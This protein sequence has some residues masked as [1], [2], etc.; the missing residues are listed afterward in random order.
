VRKPNF[1]KYYRYDELTALL[2]QYA[3]EFPNL[4]KLE[5]I[6]KSHE[7]RTVWLVTVTNFKSGSD[8][9]KPALWVDGNLHASEV[10]ASAAA[11]YHLHTLVSKY[12]K[13]KLVTRALDTR[14][15]YI[16]PR[17]NPDGAEWALAD[18]PKVVR[19]STRPY[20][21]NEEPVDGLIEED[22]DGDGR[23]LFM[24]VPDTNGTWKVYPKEPRLLVRRDPTEAGGKYYRVLPEGLLKNYDGTTIE[25]RRPKEGLDFNRNF[26]V[27]WK[28]EAEQSGS[29]PYPVSEPE[30]KNLVDFIVKHP[31][32]TGVITF[33][34][35]AAV[36]LRPYDDRSDEA[37][38]A[39]DLWTYQKIGDHGTKMTGYAN[40][41]VYHDFRYH[42]KTVT[43]G[44]FDTWM[45]DHLGV[46]G[47]TVELW[48]PM[49]Q[50][51]LKG[52]KYID[53]FR[54]HPVEDD[55]K[56]LKWSDKNLGEDGY[57]DWY[58][59]QHPQLGKVELGG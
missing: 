44:A 21:Y 40:V 12:G 30:T 39:E 56:L 28:Q 18:N 46:F 52:Y 10:A 54:E 13:D 14:A 4:L 22:I 19:S 2:K 31:N 6:G 59:F 1:N 26:P 20:P 8:S 42:P 48:S 45:Y 55:L 7:G 58:A 27:V 15:F 57:V 51:G 50:A 29:G 53:W 24:R 9:D 32:I 3:R 47:W 25:I 5:S 41:S 38:P 11:L 36:L 37:F 43:T 33:H 16:V 17:V 35:F 23:I 49:K 34:T